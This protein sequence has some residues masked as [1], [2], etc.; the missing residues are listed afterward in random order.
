M[1]VV[2]YV[3]LSD[4]REKAGTI[5]FSSPFPRDCC[6]QRRAERG[7]SWESPPLFLSPHLI[8]HRHNF[9]PLTTVHQRGGTSM[10]TRGEGR[11]DRRQVN[12]HIPPPPPQVLE[13]HAYVA[14]PP[15]QRD[16]HRAAAPPDAPPPAPSATL[17]PT[18][19]VVGCARAGAP[20]P[21]HCEC[22]CG[23]R[24]R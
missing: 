21:K 23:G 17:N 16:T 13:Y 8:R 15:S 5:S 14:S 22:Y 4:A 3:H 18:R 9:S 24:C 20:R 2:R 7:R 19:T 11:M 12:I 10:C 6:K 1:S